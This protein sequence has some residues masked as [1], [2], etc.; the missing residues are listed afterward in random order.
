MNVRCINT[1]VNTPVYYVHVCTTSSHTTFRKGTQGMD[2]LY[3]IP[4]AKPLFYLRRIV[5]RGTYCVGVI[6]SEYSLIYHNLF[7][8]IWLNILAD[9]DVAD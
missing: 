4:K 2:P 7:S 6:Y 3:G 8:R 5:E 1:Q 9:K